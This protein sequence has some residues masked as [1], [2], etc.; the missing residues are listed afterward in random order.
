MFYHKTNALFGMSFL[1][2]SIDHPI[3]KYYAKNESFNKFKL[4][5]SKTGTTEESLARAEKLGFKTELKAINPLNN[6][7]EV[8]VYFAN[9]F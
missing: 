7:H 6:K 8:P 4:D 3:A 2:L 1:A 5:C 9:L